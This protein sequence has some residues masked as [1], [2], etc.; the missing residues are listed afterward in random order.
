MLKPF[1]LLSNSCQKPGKSGVKPLVVVE[2]WRVR[3]NQR[4]WLRPGTGALRSG[5][6]RSRRFTW[7]GPAGS[8]VS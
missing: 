5:A 1:N 4:M 6:R 8:V 3:L 7:R 2:T